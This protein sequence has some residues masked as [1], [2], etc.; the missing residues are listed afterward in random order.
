[1]IHILSEQIMTVGFISTAQIS[2]ALGFASW[3]L[4]WAGR[5]SHQL[6]FQQCWAN[7]GEFEFYFSRFFIIII[8]YFHQHYVLSNFLS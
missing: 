8:C 3:P 2:L 1:M 4:Y 6:G 5:I 7:S